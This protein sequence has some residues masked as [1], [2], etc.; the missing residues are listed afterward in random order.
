VR[1][2][3]R[4]GAWVERTLVELAPTRVLCSHGAA[5]EGADCALRRLGARRDAWG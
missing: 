2:R 1:D 4:H 5:I 3:C